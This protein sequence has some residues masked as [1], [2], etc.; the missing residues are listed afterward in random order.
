MAKLKKGI[1]GPISGKIGPVVGSSW[2][3]I[4]YIKSVTKASKKRVQSPAQ[5]AHHQK[6]KFLTRWLRPLHQFVMIGFKNLAKHNTEINAAFSYNFKAA[7][8]GIGHDV[9]IDYASF[10]ISKGMLNGIEQPSIT[11]LDENMLQLN[12][13]Y[14]EER[15]SLH[16][17]QLMLAIYNDELGLTDGFIGGIKRSAK[18]CTFKFD[19]KLVGKPFHVF[20]GLIALNGRESSESQY[21]GRMEP[22]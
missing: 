14:V 22:L 20:V 6:F 21:L 19:R 1:L 12:W 8:I 5:L 10:R 2:K 18:T 3:G 4:P 7:L 11:L 9:R 16:N 15:M 17:D 13:Q